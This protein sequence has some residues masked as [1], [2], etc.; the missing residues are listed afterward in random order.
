M[1]DI[2]FDVSYHFNE[3]LQDVPNNPT[4]M[5]Q[6]LTFLQ[7]QLNEDEIET[8]HRIQ[9]LGLLGGYARMLKDFLAEEQ[10][11]TSA[12]ELSESLG[13]KRLKTANMVKKVISL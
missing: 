12:I 2:P 8:R 10:A 7:S 13:D 11:L 4:E 3:D 9:L 6:A 1:I 5:R